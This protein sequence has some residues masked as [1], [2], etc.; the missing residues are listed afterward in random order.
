MHQ[1]ITTE[2]ATPSAREWVQLLNKYRLPSAKRG[3]LELIVTIVPLIL[4]W[5]LVS[6]GDVESN[7]YGT[8][9]V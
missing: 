9:V 3:I 8:P 7:E 6:A 5:W 4:L 2:T 1:Q